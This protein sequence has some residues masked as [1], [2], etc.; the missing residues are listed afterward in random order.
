VRIDVK[1]QKSVTLSHFQLLLQSFFVNS[2]LLCAFDNWYKWQ[3]IKTYLK[4]LQKRFS[5]LIFA[6]PIKSLFHRSRVKIIKIHVFLNSLLQ[7]FTEFSLKN[8]YFLLRKCFYFNFNSECLILC[9]LIRAANWRI[10]ENLKLIIH[11]SNSFSK[12][13]K[14][15]FVM[16][17][18]FLLENEF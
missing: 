18:K 7:S 13:Y 16:F 17:S 10:C 14:L 11:I 8:E 3:H 12:E 6:H 4:K 9:F 2:I 1:C 15:S 5:G